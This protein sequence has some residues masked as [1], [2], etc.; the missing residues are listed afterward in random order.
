MQITFRFEKKFPTLTFKYLKQSGRIRIAQNCKIKKK[1]INR[2]ACNHEN[3]YRQ[4]KNIK[5]QR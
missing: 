3:I 5:N 4:R 2:I 1:N